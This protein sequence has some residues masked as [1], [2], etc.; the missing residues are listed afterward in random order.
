MAKRDPGEE[1]VEVAEGDH[2]EERNVDRVVEHQG[3]ARDQA[4]EIAEAAE[5]EVLAAAGKGIGRGELGIAEADERE[6][7]AGRQKRQGRKAQGCQGNDAQCG[8]DVRADGRVAPHVGAP[9]RYVPPKLAPGDRVG[10]VVA[11]RW[12]LHSRP[13]PTI[14]D[15]I[16]RPE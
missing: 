2:G 6:Y 8:V 9:H 15:R 3:G 11:V 13:N 1:V 10:W 7:D 4:R 5:G 14:F 12:R 16:R